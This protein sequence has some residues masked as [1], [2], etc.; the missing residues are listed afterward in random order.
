MGKDRPSARL[1]LAVTCW[2]IVSVVGTTP[3]T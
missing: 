1:M 3:P 2:S